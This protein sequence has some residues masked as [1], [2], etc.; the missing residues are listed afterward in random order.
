MYV[1]MTRARQQLYLSHARSRYHQG[2]VLFSVRSRFVEEIDHLHLT[3]RGQ[4]RHGSGDSVAG[5]RSVAR[6]PHRHTGV[7][8]AQRRSTG[9][10]IYASDS[11]PRYEDESQEHSALCMWVS[12]SLM[13]PSG[14]DA[15]LH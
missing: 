8:F 11:M 10:R 7:A 6:H 9:G 5:L 4:E 15:S 13:R 3:F 1:G 14:R 2:E 12:L